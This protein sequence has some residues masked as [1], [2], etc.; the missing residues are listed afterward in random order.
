MD[1][2][3]DPLDASFDMVIS[4]HT[5]LGF[6]SAGLLVYG[7]AQISKLWLAGSKISNRK[8]VFFSII[9]LLLLRLIWTLLPCLGLTFAVPPMVSEETPNLQE[10]LSLLSVCFFL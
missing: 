5:F 6:W 8:R 9:S 10:D 1:S 7:L 4:L 3:Q 2:Q